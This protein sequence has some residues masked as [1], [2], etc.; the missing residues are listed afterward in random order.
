MLDHPVIYLAR[1]QAQR[2]ADHACAVRKHPLDSKVGLAGVG[3]AKHG[4]DTL[5]VTGGQ[6]RRSRK[7]R[8]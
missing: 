5:I 4:P 8:C 1:E 6:V 7:G 2:Q 3:R